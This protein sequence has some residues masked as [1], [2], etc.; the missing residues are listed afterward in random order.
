MNIE[1]PDVINEK[2]LKSILDYRSK[3]KGICEV[4]TRDHMKVAFFGRFVVLFQFMFNKEFKIINLM[5]INFSSHK[6]IVDDY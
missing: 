5:V 6:Y 4:L 2:E 1:C 3:V